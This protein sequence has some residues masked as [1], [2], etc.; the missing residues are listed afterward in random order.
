MKS[1]IES[2]V[3]DSLNSRIQSEVKVPAGR[4]GR[5]GARAGQAPAGRA[6]R[7]G[8]PGG[9]VGGPG[10][11]GQSLYAIQGRAQSTQ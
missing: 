11:S 9:Q 1:M 3:K 8:R 2:E 6:S 7:P 10:R 4:L 5:M